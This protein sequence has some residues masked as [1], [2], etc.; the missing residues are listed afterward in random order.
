MKQRRG[1]GWWT[2]EDLIHFPHGRGEARALS[3]YL[4]LQP[5]SNCG[6]HLMEGT[7][8]CCLFDCSVSNQENPKPPHGDTWC[9]HSSPCSAER[10]HPSLSSKHF[11]WFLAWCLL[12]KCVPQ[13]GSVF[14]IPHIVCYCAI[15]FLITHYAIIFLIRIRINCKL[16]ICN[17]LYHNL[18]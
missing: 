5:L 18:C 8:N 12:S 15:I 16:I 4:H 10:L 2:E 17:E 14:L 1:E 11:P 7:R 13:S 6:N 9:V 3:L